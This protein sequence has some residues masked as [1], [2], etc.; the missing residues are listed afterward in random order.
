MGIMV[1]A[2]A[3]VCGPAFGGAA[4][5]QGTV[6]DIDGQDVD[7]SK[8]KGEVVMIVN[9]ASKCGFTPQYEQ[10]QAVYSK[11]KDQGF[12]VLGFPANDFMKQEPGTDEEIKEFCTSKFSVA[13][14]MFSKITVKGEER[15]ELYKQLT[16]KDANGEF[17]GEIGWNFTKFLVN[18]NGE[19]VARYDSKTKPDDAAVVAK[20]EEE[21]KKS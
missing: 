2:A 14:P 9:V 17:G 18:R 15:P 13:F 19:V 3:I 11:Y 8:Y 6:K 21:L 5:L 20:I 10:L 16:S 4:V 12:T 1:A 7:L